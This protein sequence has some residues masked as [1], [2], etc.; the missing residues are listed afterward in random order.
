MPSATRWIAGLETG[1]YLVY[2][3]SNMQRD[4]NRRIAQALTPSLTEFLSAI[5]G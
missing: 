4:E 3:I 5:Q 2:V 1:Q